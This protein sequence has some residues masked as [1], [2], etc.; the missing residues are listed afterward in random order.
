M[1]HYLFLLLFI[2]ILS[3]CQSTVESE[4]MDEQMTMA[5]PDTDWTMTSP[6]SQGIDSL[7]LQIA[8]DTLRSYCHENGIDET[9]ILRNGRIIFAGD[10]IDRVH[11]LWSCS[12]SFTSTVLAKLIEE[13]KCNLKDKAA[14]Y[15]PL[16]AEQYPSATLRH[17][18]TM[19]S[20]YSAV[21]DDRWDGWVSEDWSWTPYEPA[22]PHF[23]S[24]E[25]YCYW[26]ENM[27]MLGRVL[28]QVAK[29][30]LHSYLKREVTDKIG[31][32]EWTWSAEGEIDSLV[33]RNGCTNIEMSARQ[34]AR[35]GHLFLNRGKWKDEQIVPAEWVDEAL[36][37]QVP[38]DLT[39]IKM[40]DRKIEGR[41][42]YGYNWWVKG[43]AD[44]MPN[45]PDGTAYMSGFN[46]NLCFVVPAWKM[47]VIRM[48]T[49]GN[50]EEGKRLVYDR[51]FG[52]LAKAIR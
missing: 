17:F 39:H 40:D 41:G 7:Q 9:I 6:E 32:G 14:Q 28:T 8:L 31:L 3:A 24:G 2:L 15:E 18:T 49:D 48:G 42:R 51:F 1:Q 4:V 16:L 46:N 35:I 10:S 30:D 12:K 38:L 22:E 11:N 27:M 13:G 25:G 21:G 33:I 36:S 44:D 37:N 45:T 43:V 34:L 23:P 20:G 29:E 5:F 26:D 19:T 52:E 47:V 50:P